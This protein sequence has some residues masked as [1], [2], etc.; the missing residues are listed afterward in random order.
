M[1]PYLTNR[2]KKYKLCKL[3]YA[4]VAQLDRVSDSDSGGRAFESHQACQ[5]PHTVVWGFLIFL[6]KF[7]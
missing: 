6:N 3:L 5:N 2:E 1:Y 7:G 4:P